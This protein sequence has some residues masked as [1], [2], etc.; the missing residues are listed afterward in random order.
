MKIAI[1]DDDKVQLELLNNYV[2][3]WRKN[4]E[5]NCEIF[6]YPS[7][8]AFLF[9]YEDMSF[10]LILLD[11]Q[12]NDMSGIDMAKKIREKKDHVAIIFITGISDY[13]FEGYDVNAVNYLLK[14]VKE[15]KLYDCLDQVA[16]EIIKEKPH[17][18]VEGKKIEKIY[19]HNIIYLE[20]RGHQCLINCIDK[21]IESKKGIQNYEDLLDKCIFYRCHRS[22]IINI[23]K[24]SSI[25]KNE[26][27]MIND[28]KIPI[29][30]GK[31]EEVNKMF[32]KYCRS[33]LC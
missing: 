24:I 5:E 2:D 28:E 20:S 18:I 6:S 31:W 13:V 21:V 26:V 25:S 11:I 33:S 32:L 15:E 12:M 8:E 1:C 7:A 4:R 22:Y 29:A 16:E 14:P 3:F 19:L 30:R 23:S 9:S 17:I 27:D 10:D